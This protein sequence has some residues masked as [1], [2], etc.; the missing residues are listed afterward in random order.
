MRT[1]PKFPWKSPG[2]II[3]SL[4][5]FLFFDIKFIMHLF[6]LSILRGLQVT[7]YLHFVCLWVY[8]WVYE[9]AWHIFQPQEMGPGKFFKP[10]GLQEDWVLVSSVASRPKRP[11]LLAALVCFH[12]LRKFT[13]FPR[14]TLCKVSYFLFSACCDVF[15]SST[16]SIWSAINT[17]L[18]L[19]IFFWFPSG[20][21]HD[22]STIRA[23]LL[24]STGAINTVSQ[25]NI[26]W[27]Y[28]IWYRLYH[29]LKGVIVLTKTTFLGKLTQMAKRKSTQNNSTQTTTGETHTR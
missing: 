12:F 29:I 14:V 13:V 23:R 24:Y 28:Y 1:L 8:G 4:I 11:L 5:W 27:F 20:V 16:N 10:H 3:N 22:R 25:A 21:Y 19:Y 2:R 17:L 18:F 15:N 26:S 7:H 6:F 9:S